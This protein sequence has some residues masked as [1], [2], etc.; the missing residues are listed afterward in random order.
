LRLARR[1]AK[2]V[3]LRSRIEPCGLRCGWVCR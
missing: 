3:A 2:P 1:Q